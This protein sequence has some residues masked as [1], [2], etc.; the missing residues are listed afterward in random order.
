MSINL[1]YRSTIKSRPF[2]Y[3]ETK[4]LACL[5][6]QGLNELEI[7]EI[8]LRK[9]IFQV[10][11]EARKR[12]IASTVRSRLNTLDDYLAKKMID[13]D[14]ETSKLIVLYTILKTDN[15]ILF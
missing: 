4:Q 2:L 6:L 13:S 9:N 11:T 12:E 3:V 7:K 1:K 14:L 8:V 5:I 15:N 10:K